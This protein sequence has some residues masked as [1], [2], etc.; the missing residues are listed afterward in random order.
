[1]WGG[2]GRIPLAVTRFGERLR[3]CLGNRVQSHRLVHQQDAVTAGVIFEALTIGGDDDDRQRR[4]DS[5]QLSG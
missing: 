5:A 3:Y 4:I 1:M 2:L